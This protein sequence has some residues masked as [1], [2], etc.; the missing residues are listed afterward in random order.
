MNPAKKQLTLLTLGMTLPLL[1]LGGIGFGVDRVRGKP[2]IMWDEVVLHITTVGIVLLVSGIFL[3]NRLDARHKFYYF[4][5]RLIK[6]LAC[7][8]GAPLAGL[9][10]FFLGMPV[11]FLYV[12]LGCALVTILIFVLPRVINYEKS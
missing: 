10:L 12:Y 4:Q 6:S 9:L 5:N 3:A 1:L 11:K 2:G 8:D 7:I